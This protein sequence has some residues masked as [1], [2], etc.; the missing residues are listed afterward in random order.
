MRVQQLVEAGSKGSKTIFGGRRVKEFEFGIWPPQKERASCHVMYPT[1]QTRSDFFSSQA[2]SK[3]NFRFLTLWYHFTA[4]LDVSHT[5]ERYW[6]GVP[7][8]LGRLAQA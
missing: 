2:Q 5:T 4:V 6:Y 1:P 8:Q 3:P 7:R